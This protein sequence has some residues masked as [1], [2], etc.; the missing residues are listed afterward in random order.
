MTVGGEKILFLILI[1]TLVA[2]GMASQDY[3]VRS[4]Y[5]SLQQPISSIPLIPEE[6]PVWDLP[7]GIFIILIGGYITEILV[8]FKLWTLLGYRRVTRSN[9]LEQPGRFS[10]FQAILKNPGI[11]MQGL[12]RET[13]IHLGTVR[14]HLQMLTITGKITCSQDAATL[15][16]YENNGTYSETQKQVLKH[17]RNETRNQILDV[18]TKHPSTG[19]DEIARLLGF[20]GATITWH[21]KVLEAARLIEVQRSGRIVRYRIP[22]DVACYLTTYFP[23]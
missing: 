21:M 18:L 15:R 11:H 23:S 5:E 1:L 2:P 6:I 13:H 22:D 10:V 16:F 3:H 12:A 19:R 14:H 8:F 17:L 9:V 4:A 20:T 7:L